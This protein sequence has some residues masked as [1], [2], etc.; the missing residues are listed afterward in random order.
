MPGFRRRVGEGGGGWG[1]RISALAKMSVNSMG[2][3]GVRG[4]ARESEM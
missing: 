3:G 2:G 4:R 1:L